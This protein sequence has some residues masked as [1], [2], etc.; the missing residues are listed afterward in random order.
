METVSTCETSVCIYQTIRRCHLHTRCK[1]LK[2][3]LFVLNCTIF[4]SLKTIR[5]LLTATFN[6]KSYLVWIFSVNC[7][8]M[9]SVISFWLHGALQS[10]NKWMFISK[11]WVGLT[12]ILKFTVYVFGL[13]IIYLNNGVI[14]VQFSYRHA[15][16]SWLGFWRMFNS[17]AWIGSGTSVFL[18]RHR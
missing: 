13:L 6:E 10:I 5:G 4:C 14:W 11:N 9:R 17:K 15:I 16:F 12:L 3:H 7:M 2:S 1:N 8:Y 18:S